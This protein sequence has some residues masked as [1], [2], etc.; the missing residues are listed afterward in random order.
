[1][2]IISAVVFT[3]LLAT[4]ATAVEKGAEK[5]VDKV[6]FPHDPEKK[7]VYRWSAGSTMPR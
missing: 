2:A 7:G 4:N 3:V 5:V 6:L 1:M